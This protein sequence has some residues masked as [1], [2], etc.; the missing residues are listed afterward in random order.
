MA[1]VRPKFKPNIVKH[2]RTKSSKLPTDSRSK[3]RENYLE[4]RSRSRKLYVNVI[5]GVAFYIN[6]E[7]KK[8]RQ[9]A[10]SSNNRTPKN[11][12][13]TVRSSARVYF[14]DQFSG[15]ETV[16]NVKKRQFNKNT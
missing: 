13:S 9:K 11:G 16:R 10:R 1:D 5:D 8:V 15:K 6:E 3:L 14:K 7:N 4:Q 2:H 12:E